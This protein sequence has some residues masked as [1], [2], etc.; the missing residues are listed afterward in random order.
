M[1][2]HIKRSTKKENCEN[3]PNFRKIP[4]PTQHVYIANRKVRVQMYEHDG[5]SNISQLE[6]TVAVYLQVG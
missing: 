6:T 1:C 4:I 3:A 5:F 2:V